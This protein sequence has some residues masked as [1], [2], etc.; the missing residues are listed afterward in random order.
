MKKEQYTVID[1]F[2]NTPTT[3]CQLVRWYRMMMFVTL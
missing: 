3:D 2:A 1:L